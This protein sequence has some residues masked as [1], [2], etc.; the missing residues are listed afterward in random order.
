MN[1]FTIRPIKPTESLL[2]PMLLTKLA[3]P[4]RSAKPLNLIGFNKATTTLV[5]MDAIIHLI[6]IITRKAIIFGIV[7]KTIPTAFANEIQRASV[8][9]LTTFCIQSSKVR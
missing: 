7:A 4:D 2:S 1:R 3:N 5:T 9:S 6:I 8:Q